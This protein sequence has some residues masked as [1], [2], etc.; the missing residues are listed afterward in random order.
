[1]DRETCRCRGFGFVTFA[2]AEDAKAA[3]K[4]L[5]GDVCIAKT[6]ALKCAGLGSVTFPVN[7]QCDF[8]I[9]MDVNE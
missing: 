6:S 4:G 5:N 2:K 3:I 1:M 8:I 7:F 9:A